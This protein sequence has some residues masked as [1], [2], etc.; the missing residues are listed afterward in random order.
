LDAWLRGWCGAA[1]QCVSH[2]GIPVSVISAVCVP[3]VSCHGGGPTP[4]SRAV[5]SGSSIPSTSSSHAVTRATAAGQSEYSDAV[6]VVAVRTG[7]RRLAAPIKAS[8]AAGS[9]RTYTS[10]T[11]G[12]VGPATVSAS[13]P[14]IGVAAPATPSNHQPL[15]EAVRRRLKISGTSATVS[16]STWV[17]SA[18]EAALGSCTCASNH[19][20]VR[21]SWNNINIS[22]H[23]SAVST[24]IAAA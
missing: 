21:R 14:A 16:I 15:I 2:R 18:I 12:A 5:R 3:A 10:S 8:S 6:D 11:V 13:R 19:D 20:P 4:A 1:W 17:S 24:P 7:V 9:N 23:H 22:F